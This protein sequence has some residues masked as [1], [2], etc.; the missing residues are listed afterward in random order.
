MVI[1]FAHFMA[2]FIIALFLM[3]VFQMYFPDSQVSKA[4]A[5]LDG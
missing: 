5:F 2:Q 4:L 3:R 1:S